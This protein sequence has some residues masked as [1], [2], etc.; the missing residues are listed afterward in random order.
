MDSVK[1]TKTLKPE[2]TKFQSEP[3]MLEEC[4]AVRDETVGIR[5]AAV[6]ALPTRAPPVEQSSNSLIIF[7]I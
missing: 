7:F 3:K 2:S 5:F 4:A 6:G 1:I